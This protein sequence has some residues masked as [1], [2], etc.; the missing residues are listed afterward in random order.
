[1][2]ARAGDGF[3]PFAPPDLEHY[4]P[5]ADD[6]LK[7]ITYVHKRHRFV[8]QLQIPSTSTSVWDEQQHHYSTWV[9]IQPGAE[10]EEPFVVGNYYKSPR[11][12][13]DI[14]RLRNDFDYI[15]THCRRHHIRNWALCGDHRQSP[16]PCRTSTICCRTFGKN[17]NSSS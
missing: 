2:D 12:E 9:L 16:R 13:R 6:L 1:M 3:V 15:S 7:T 17:S 8:E 4:E 11:L 10:L 14:A 5:F